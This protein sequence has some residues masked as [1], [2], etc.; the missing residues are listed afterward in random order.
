MCQL[1]RN[2][3]II[4][5]RISSFVELISTSI[6]PTGKL[7]NISHRRVVDLVLTFA[8][9][10]RNIDFYSHLCLCCSF[11]YSHHYHALLLCGHKTTS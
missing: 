9:L 6:L 3:I 11:L 4:S 1:N 10:V 7:K 8:I 5:D 2:N